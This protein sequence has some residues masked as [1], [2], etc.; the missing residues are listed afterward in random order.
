MLKNKYTEKPYGT[1]P[2]ISNIVASGR[3]PND[4]DIVKAYNEIEWV[5]SE[6]NPETYCALLVKV[7]IGGVKKHITIYR[8]G[9]FIIAGAKSIEELNEIY[10][11]LLKKLKG[12]NFIK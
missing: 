2:K 3:L 1:K 8:N 6:Y 5:E 4:I 12:G 11:L 10:T 7:K 9:K